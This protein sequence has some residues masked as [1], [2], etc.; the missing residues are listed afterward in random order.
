VRQAVIRLRAE[1]LP[2]QRVGQQD[3][4]QSTRDSQA[5]ACPRKP[6]TV[7]GLGE[8][9]H[10]EE[11]DAE[12]GEEQRFR[13]D[14]VLRHHGHAQQESIADGSTRYP[15]KEKPPHDQ[16][17]EKPAHEIEV[18][19]VRMGDHRRAEAAEPSAER[20]R[21]GRGHQVSREK[22]VPGEGG[23]GQTGGERDGEGQPRPGEESQRC[24]G[25]AE[26]EQGGVGHQIHAGRGVDERGEEGIVKVGGR[27]RGVVKEPLSLRLIETRGRDLIAAQAAPERAGHEQGR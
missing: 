21:H 22:Q 20:G 10:D 19:V 25:N 7:P 3:K 11:A 8:V 2:P 6:A 17:N 23:A 26:P 18:A 15:D 9:K 27:M 14:E 5:E 13:A 1:E 4:G 12:R 16:R 24:Q